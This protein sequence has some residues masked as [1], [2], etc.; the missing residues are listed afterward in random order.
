VHPGHDAPPVTFT[1][2][3]AG[4][5]WPGLRATWGAL[6]AGLAHP[7]LFLSEAWVDCWLAVYGPGMRPLLWT[8]RTGGEVVAM[9]LLVRVREWRGPVPVRCLYL[10]TAGE[11][12]DSVTLEHNTL[13]V[14]PGLEDVAWRAFADMLGRL[15]WDELVLVGADT[16]TAERVRR[17]FGPWPVHMDGRSAPY[18]PLGEVRGHEQGALGL[19]SANTRS[20][21]RRAARVGSAAAPLTLCEATTPA[22]RVAAWHELGQLHAARWRARGQSGAFARPRWLAFHER[23]LAMAPQATRLLQ[24]RAGGDTVAALYL[25][26]HRGHVAFY[27]SGVRQADADNREKPGMLLHTMAMDRLAAEG[28]EEYDFLAS[29]GPDVRYKRSLARQERML[30]WGTVIRPTWRSRLV[31]GLRILRQAVRSALASLAS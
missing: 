9:A 28:L 22:K 19:M 13:L 27:Q 6:H 12:A 30:W 18:T 14:R 21:L 1:L 29:E 25:L 20:Q 11:G 26:Q 2:D 15:S 3:N 8:A 10:N 5:A 7:T 4:H 24:L 31:R 23:L 17:L 16:Y